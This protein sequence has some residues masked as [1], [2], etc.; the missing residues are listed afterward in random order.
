MS[1]V[2]L[3]MLMDVAI[4]SNF[5]G[6]SSKKR[7]LLASQIATL[8]LSPQTHL[9]FVSSSKFPSCGNVSVLDS[10]YGVRV[11]EAA[12]ASILKKKKRPIKNA[13]KY[14]IFTLF[15]SAWIEI[16]RKILLKLFN[17]TYVIY[18]HIHI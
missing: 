18:I 6:V 13:K 8:S 14:H 9:A 2:I 7:C 17:C 1:V 12:V 4:Q 16:N 5:G 11:G 10:G 15:A 3:R